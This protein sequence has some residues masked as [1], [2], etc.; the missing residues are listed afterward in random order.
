MGGKQ[1][2]AA[3]KRMVARAVESGE[4][5]PAQACR[6]YGISASMLHGWRQEYKAHGEAAWTIAEPDPTVALEQRIVQL[7]RLAGQLALENARLKK[8][9]EP[10]P[11]RKNT[12]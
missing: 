11:L 9:L 6:E 1:Y 8:V 5:R 12:P 10:S 4:K 2:D 7:E 3:F